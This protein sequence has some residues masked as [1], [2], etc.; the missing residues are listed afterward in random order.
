MAQIG[1]LFLLLGKSVLWTNIYKVGAS[2]DLGAGQS[3]FMVEMSEVGYI[4][5]CN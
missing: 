5:I 3:T 2:D 4:E 1:F